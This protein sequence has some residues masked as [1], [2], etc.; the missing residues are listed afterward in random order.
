MLRAKNVQNLGDFGQLQTSITN[1][2][3]TDLHPFRRYSWSKFE[4]VRSQHSIQNRKKAC[5][6]QRF[7]AR[8]AKKVRWTLVH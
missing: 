3:G 7:L 5:D 4:V 6:R 8:S 2:F 1:I